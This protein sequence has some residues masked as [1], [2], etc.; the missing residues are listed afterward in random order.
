LRETLGGG[1]A[2]PDEFRA[3][4]EFGQDRVEHDATERIVLDAEDA[5]RL[6]RGRRPLLGARAG[7]LRCLGTGQCHRQREGSAAAAPLRHRDVA[8]HRARDLF[9]RR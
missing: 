8:A 5:Q 4:T 7:R 3:M 9:H 2:A 6:R 1:L